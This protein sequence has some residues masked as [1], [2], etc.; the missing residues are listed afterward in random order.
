MTGN[1]TQVPGKKI[2]NVIRHRQLLPI[3][4]EKSKILAQSQTQTLK[5]VGN[6]KEA[7]DCTE[8]PSLKGPAYNYKCF[9]RSISC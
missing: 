5:K 6:F 4:N 3:S 7:P 2:S 1:V 9:H 8:E